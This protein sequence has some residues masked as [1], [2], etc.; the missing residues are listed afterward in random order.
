MRETIFDLPFQAISSGRPTAFTTLFSTACNKVLV[1][2][3]S[4]PSR[5]YIEQAPFLS[6]LIINF[7]VAET[8]DNLG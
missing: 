8:T 3:S 1:K 6:A 2:G 5:I 4:K 7:G